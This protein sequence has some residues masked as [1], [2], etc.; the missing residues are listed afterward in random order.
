MRVIPF[1]EKEN[2]KEQR[3]VAKASSAAS[4]KFISLKHTHTSEVL[5]SDLIKLCYGSMDFYYIL[6]SILVCMFEIFHYKIYIFKSSKY[7]SI[8]QRNHQ[9]K[10][11][12]TP[13]S[14]SFPL[15][16]MNR[17]AKSI[18][19]LWEGSF[20]RMPHTCKCVSLQISAH[21]HPGFQTRASPFGFGTSWWSLKC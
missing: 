6:F 10:E 1:A 8:S 20:E 17:G 9:S 19:Y 5:C 15:R 14:T 11:N 7:E 13:C 18:L 3:R 4:I 16:T 12:K 2:G 21:I